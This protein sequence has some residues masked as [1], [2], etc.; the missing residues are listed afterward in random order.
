MYHDF[1]QLT[2]DP[3]RLSPDHRF[4][5]G[6]RSF[7]R[8]RTYMEYALNRGEGFVM[9]TGEPGTGKS[10]LIEDLFAGLR[11]EPVVKAKLVSTQ[12]YAEDLLRMVAYSFDIQAESLDKATL[13]KK[14][15]DM[16]IQ[17]RRGG[18][19]V[20][21]VVDEAQ[22]LPPGALEE[23]RL[24]TNLQEDSEPLLQIFLVGQQQLRDRIRE[25]GM[26]Q[27]HQRIVAACHL[28]PLKLEETKAYVK[29]RLHCAGWTGDPCMSDA[30]FYIIQ[31]FSDGVPRRINLICSRLFLHGSVEEVHKFAAKDVRLVLRELQEEDLFSF[32]EVT[33]EIGD[34]LVDVPLGVSDDC[35]PKKAR[36]PVAT[37]HSEPAMSAQHGHAETFIDAADSVEQQ[38]SVQAPPANG[39]QSPRKSTSAEGPTPAAVVTPMSK[40]ADEQTPAAQQSDVVAQQGRKASWIGRSLMT[41]VAT[42]LIGVLLYGLDPAAVRT[43]LGL[44]T[45]L[46][47]SVPTQAS[48]DSSTRQDEATT[49]PQAEPDGGAEVSGQSG[50]A[51]LEQ[52][53]QGAPEPRPLE[54]APMAASVGPPP[55]DPSQTA[56]QS[57]ENSPVTEA[58]QEPAMK[59]DVGSSTE[60]ADSVSPQEPVQQVLGT[61]QQVDQ[62]AAILARMDAIERALEAL[63]LSV[64]QTEDGALEVNLRRAVPF[65][66]GSAVISADSREFLDRV[67]SVLRVYDDISLRVVGHTDRSGS[68]TYNLQLSRQRAA[69]V[70]DYLKQVTSARMIVSVEGR[71]SSDPVVPN[72][73][74]QRELN[75]RTVLYIEPIHEG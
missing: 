18:R 27:I 37:E 44:S 50:L 3:F 55:Q 1:Y 51:D 56:V 32:D 70:A 24:L 68:E 8:A 71:G 48:K 36:M 49:L 46:P 39:G 61:P 74:A 14:L 72:D 16:F 60:A 22:D 25:R 2:T 64:A 26:E 7:K 21:L 62:A 42:A 33:A 31:Y 75:R 63:N 41:L 47:G 10:T 52:A 45:D 15:T 9:V 35:V 19:R 5:F 13:L 28:E 4:C 59:A 43:F 20:L 66:R 65:G 30:A 17:H 40:S 34:V 57:V 11:G 38:P 73:S 23:L 6:H 53:G 54:G 58:A 69:A 29:H 12:L 67:A